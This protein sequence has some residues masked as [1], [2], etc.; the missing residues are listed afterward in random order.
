MTQEETVAAELKTAG[1][2]LVLALVAAENG[3]RAAAH[4]SAWCELAKRLEHEI[5]AKDHCGRDE[6]AHHG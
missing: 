5:G 4:R 6:P 2:S 1:A 3:E